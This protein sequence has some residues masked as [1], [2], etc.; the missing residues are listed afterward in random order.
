MAMMFP[1]FIWFA[2]P[3][4]NDV[5]REK[6]VTPF[7]DMIASVFQ[8]VMIVALCIII[9]EYRQKPMKKGLFRGIVILLALYYIGWCLYYAGIYIVFNVKKKC[10]C[11]IISD[12][13]YAMSCS[14]WHY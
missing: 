9:N 7:V 1:N 3:A 4:V 12:C 5:L 14:V 2:V 8:V 11:A 6:S 13:I 10:N